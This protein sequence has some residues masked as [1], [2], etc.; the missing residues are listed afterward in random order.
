VM[1]RMMVT[2]HALEN[3]EGHPEEIG[4]SVWVR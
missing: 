2:I 4:G 3:F 1:I